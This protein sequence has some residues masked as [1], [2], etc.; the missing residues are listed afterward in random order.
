MLNVEIEK[1]KACRSIAKLVLEKAL[2]RPDFTILVTS[3]AS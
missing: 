2:D 3:S 1:A